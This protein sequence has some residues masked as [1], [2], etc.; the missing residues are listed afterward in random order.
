LTS[1]QLEEMLAE[2]PLGS[3]TAPVTLI[4][5]SSLTCPHCASFHIQTLPAIRANYV[6]TGKARFIHRDFPLDSTAQDAALL[7][8]C[9]GTRYHEALDLLYQRQSSWT[10]SSDF[11]GGMKQALSPLGM[12]ST[13][14]DSCLASNDLKNGILRIRQEGQ[15]QHGISSTPTFLINGQKIVGAVPYGTFAAAIDAAVAG[16]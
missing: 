16:K 11:R 2:R 13:Q 6:D 8:H 15:S 4:E 12:P 7:A 5:Y 1:A 14:M 10:S 3:T 9:A